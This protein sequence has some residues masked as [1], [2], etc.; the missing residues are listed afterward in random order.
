[1][2]RKR[3]NKRKSPPR[4][5][6]VVTLPKFELPVVNWQYLVNACVLAGVVCSVYLGTRWVMDQEIQAVKIEGRFERVSAMQVEAAITPYL[7]QGFISVDLGILQ[8]AVANLPWVSQASVRRSWPATLLVSVA[9]E[10]AAARWGQDGLL[11]IYG[12]LFVEHTSHIPAELPQLSGPEGSELEVARRFFEL[13]KQL[14]QRGLTAVSL[15]VDERGAWELNLNNGMQVR[16]GAVAVTERAERFLE[17]LDRILAPVADSV[18]YI[19]MRYTNGFAIGW[20][21]GGKNRL[22]EL[23]EADPH[24]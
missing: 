9:E 19:D 4:K 12:E 11:N 1:M 22:A 18:D 20:K 23:G 17:A 7:D 13:D 2:P 15:D 14:K 21:P 6:P 5:R 3:S 10:R 8:Q 16:F 24:A